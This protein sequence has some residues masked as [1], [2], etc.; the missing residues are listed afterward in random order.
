MKTLGIAM[1][2][3]ACAIA[4]WAQ[5]PPAAGAAKGKGGR[6]GAAAEAKA[7]TPP[8]VPQVLRLVRANTYL[9]TG[10]GTNSVFRVTAQGVMLVDTKLAEPGDYERLVD[11]IRGITPQPVKFVFNTSARPASNGNNVKFQAAGAE[12]VTT[13]RAVML[14]G[15][16]ARVIRVGENTVVHFPGEKLTCLGDVDM[17]NEAVTKLA[18][19]L[20]IPGAGEPVYRENVAR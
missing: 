5:A 2:I 1:A 18:W 14:G 17:T 13:E 6:G 3:A 8:P 11:L 9:V 19:T 7:P 20:A 15:A 16:E 4:L 12:V 10:H